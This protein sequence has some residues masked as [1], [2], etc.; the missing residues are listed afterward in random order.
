M[1][2]MSNKNKKSETIGRCPKRKGGIN[3]RNS[4]NCQRCTREV[5][6]KEETRTFE[7][8][9]KRAE[10]ELLS[11]KLKFIAEAVI[12]RTLTPEKLENSGFVLK[13]GKIFEDVLNSQ[14]L[15]INQPPGDYWLMV[16]HVKENLKKIIAHKT[17]Q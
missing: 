16:T 9:N 17:Y 10:R 12:F 15:D 6:W 4:E 11:E 14:H 7:D 13:P 1:S 8:K 2:E 3:S 5:S